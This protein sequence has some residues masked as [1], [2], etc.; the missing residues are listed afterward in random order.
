MILMR[1][2]KLPK[3]R[4]KSVSRPPKEF[5][6][7]KTPHVYRPLKPMGVTPDFKWQ[8]WANGA[9]IQ[10]PK[11]FLGLQTKPK[12]ISETKN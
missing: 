1:S 3:K 12:N 4:T 2:Q 6:G 5:S 10:N 9:K 7:S 11:K 8:E